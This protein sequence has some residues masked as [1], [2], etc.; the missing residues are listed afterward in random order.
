MVNDAEWHG[1]GGIFLT[2]SA[3]AA[4]GKPAPGVCQQGPATLEVT[5]VSAKL[6]CILG[7][8]DVRC[9][10]ASDWGWHG[11]RVALLQ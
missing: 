3:E 10:A 6:E 11:N 7:R 2:S 1:V 4:P 8:S 9:S 5:A